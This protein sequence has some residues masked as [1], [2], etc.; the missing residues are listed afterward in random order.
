MKKVNLKAS[1]IACNSK[2]YSS[3]FPS[4][5]PSK[6]R[7]EEFQQKLKSNIDVQPD[8]DGTF[9]ESTSAE[10]RTTIPVIDFKL[11]FMP[12]SEISYSRKAV[13]HLLKNSIHA[14]EL[15]RLHARGEGKLC[16]LEK[17]PLLSK[18]SYARNQVVISGFCVG[19]HDILV[20]SYCAG[21][22]DKDG[23]NNDEIELKK[24]VIDGNVCYELKAVELEEKYT[25][26]VIRTYIDLMDNVYA[27]K[28]FSG[29]DDIEYM[30]AHANRTDPLT[31]ELKYFVQTERTQ[32]LGSF[33][34]PKNECT[35]W[36]D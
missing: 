4:Y 17:P 7:I 16:V 20:R 28:Y 9:Q 13:N 2:Q 31:G 32:V 14:Y 21:R 23:I 6:E 26:M 24:S 25:H 18:V 5:I 22:S 29:F 1:A 15:L 36:V 3:I 12:Q 35:D 30:V 19:N 34:V 8:Y 10:F 27:A 33:L 11:K